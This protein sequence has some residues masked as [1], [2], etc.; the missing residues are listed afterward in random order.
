MTL[1]SAIADTMLTHLRHF[2]T[3]SHVTLYTVF[4]HRYTS[5]WSNTLGTYYVV[6]AQCNSLI[7]IANVSVTV[8]A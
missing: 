6:L 4:L 1:Q 2:L 7:Q 8:G 5:N 3:V